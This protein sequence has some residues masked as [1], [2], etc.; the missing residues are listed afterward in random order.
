MSDFDHTTFGG[1]Y[2]IRHVASGKLYVGSSVDVHKR[3]R[4]HRSALKRGDHANARLQN[5]WNKYGPGAFVFEIL[6]IV[7]DL[8]DLIPREQA[9]IDHFDSSS[10]TKGYNIGHVADAPMLGRKMSP[11]AIAKSASGHRGLKMSPEAIAKVAATK[12]GRKHTPETLAKMSESQRGR[13]HTPEARARISA[14][15]KGKALSPEHRAKI[16]E[17]KKGKT[18]DAETRS[19]HSATI[20]EKWQDPEYRAKQLA[21][22]KSKSDR[23]VSAPD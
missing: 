10:R 6:E 7:D 16:S 5:A 3:R 20:K 2:A 21:A 8:R 1:I 19:K 18:W 23:P 11:E 17:S 22:R 12:R 9:A 15:R 4:E 13:K 14:A